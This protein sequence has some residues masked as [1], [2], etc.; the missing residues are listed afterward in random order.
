MS[1]LR[2]KLVL[3]YATV[4]LPPLIALGWYGGSRI[5][6]AL[7]DQGLERL[8]TRIDVLSVQ[9][10]RF[11]AGTDGDLLLLAD[12][13]ALGQYLLAL[14][15]G[16]A[17]LMGAARK[18]LA[19]GFV[20]LSEIRGTY[21]QI[22]Y[23]DSSGVERIRVDRNGDA[24]TVVAT[25]KLETKRSGTDFEE[26]MKLP[27]GKVLVSTMGLNRENGAIEDP[28]R[29]VIRYSTPVFDASSHRRGVLVI[30]V[31]AEP[32]LDLVAKAPGTGETLLLVDSGGAY[33]SHPEA[34]KLWGGDADL[35]TGENLT[36]DYPEVGPQI[37]AE[38]SLFR[39]EGSDVF[40]LAKAIAIPGVNGANLGVLVDLMPTGI[41]YATASQFRTL[42]NILTMVALVIALA[43]GAVVA[44]FVTRPIMA[45]TEAVDRMSRGDLDQPIEVVSNDETQ[46][47]AIAMERLRKS[48]K[49]MLDKYS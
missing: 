5:E 26:A 34:S 22:R 4:T 11:L 1:S 40:T 24:T 39:S 37:L 32:I 20:R 13:P 7:R 43:F 19:Q 14:D 16:D 35:K 31:A 10:E 2:N 15:S 29:P 42:F 23:I 27:K 9:I 28:H 49:L 33:L 25:E 6:T 12:T 41:L 3:A 44:H 48:M 45:L 21:H 47:L 17:A 46:T 38:K 36:R 30:G 8:E 18:N